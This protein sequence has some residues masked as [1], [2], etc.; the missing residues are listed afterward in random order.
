MRPAGRESPAGPGHESR[1]IGTPRTDR[2][3]MSAGVQ[4][5]PVPALAR[6]GERLTVAGLA[7]AAA[8][9]ATALA[10]ATAALAA[11]GGDISGFL[12][13]GILGWAGMGCVLLAKRP[14]HPIGPLLCLLGLAAAITDL[15]FAYERYTL[16]HSPG[17]LPF[18]T[19]LLW[20]NIWLGA[21]AISLSFVLLLVF[22]EGRL[23]SRRWR[24]AL[25]AAL[26]FTP[27]WVAGYAFAP[28]TMGSYLRNL[29]NPYATASAHPLFEGL[30]LLAVACVLSAAAAALAS[31]VLRWRRADRVGRQQL[32]WLLAVLPVAAAS[33]I[34]ADAVNLGPGSLTT[35]LSVA[36]GVAGWRPDTSGDRRGGV[37]VPAV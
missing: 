28:Q 11:L 34:V 2:R 4:R 21:L 16:V 35:V 8:A 26:A 31:M 36:L 33:W 13:P 22:P 14:G 30:Q 1:D 7:W 10:F 19:P 37:A 32:K 12:V 5:R 24:P 3:S 6:A 20:A 9:M 17:A 27:L 25:W 15:A 18:A 23:L 29:P